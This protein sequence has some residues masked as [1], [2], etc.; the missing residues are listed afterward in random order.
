MSTEEAGD[1]RDKIREFIVRDLNAT[2]QKDELTDT[3]PLIENGVIDSLGIFQLVSF[4]QEEFA[5]T[6]GD[7]ELVA[8]HFGTID[9]LARLVE[10]KLARPRHGTAG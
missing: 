1:I 7:D 4:V 10:G 3:Y 8:E 5:V 6:V 9:G 2:R